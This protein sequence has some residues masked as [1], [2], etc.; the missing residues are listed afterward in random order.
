MKIIKPK[1]RKK[2]PAKDSKKE[3]HY[4]QLVSI[5]C[6][7]GYRVRRERLKQGH[8]WKVASG[9]CCAEGENYV[10]LESRL[11]QDDQIGFLIARIRELEIE[12]TDEQLEGLP[13]K[14][15]KAI[16]TSEVVAEEEV[17]RVSPD[18]DG[19]SEIGASNPVS[20]STRVTSAA[21]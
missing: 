2:A 3:S 15:Q 1:K 16:R 14:L 8:G 19:A 5:L 11:S 12:V 6:D 13:A 9:S 20:A 10:F 4:R 18:A 21:V 17:D 7:A